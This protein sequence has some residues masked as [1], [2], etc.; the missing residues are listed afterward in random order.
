MSTQSVLSRPKAADDLNSGIKVAERSASE[1]SQ[2]A[3]LQQ[4]LA[5]LTMK[6]KK[7]YQRSEE[8]KQMLRAELTRDLE[9]LEETDVEAALK[10]KE[11]EGEVYKDT[12]AKSA[13]IA[14]STVQKIGNVKAGDLA[15]I[16]VGMPASVVEH[17]AE[18]TI[19]DV[20]FGDMS[21]GKVGIYA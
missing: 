10:E 5:E 17:V 4:K 6:A 8:E 16:E 20:T 14:R 1:D 21:N 2:V 13:I 11:E 15:S 19:G 3:E 18:Q 9:D 12:M 7:D